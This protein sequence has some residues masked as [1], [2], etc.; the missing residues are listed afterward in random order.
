MT[1]ADVVL[2][3]PSDYHYMYLASLIGDEFINHHWIQ[4]I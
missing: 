1:Q 3:I 4:K 2:H